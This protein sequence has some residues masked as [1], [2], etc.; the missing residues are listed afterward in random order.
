[1][2]ERQGAPASSSNKYDI[3]KARTR[4]ALPTRTKPRRWEP[5]ATRWETQGRTNRQL[6]QWRQAQQEAEV[7]TTRHRTERGERSNG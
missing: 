2:V 4:F 5:C 7:E 6:D 1:M 3:T